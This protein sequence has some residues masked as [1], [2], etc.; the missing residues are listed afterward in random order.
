MKALTWHGKGDVRCEHVPDPIIQD[1]HDAIIKVTACVICESDVHLYDSVIP[2][3]K[4]G[5]VLD[6]ETMGEVDGSAT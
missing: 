2:S 6:H 4:S 1:H 3:L 5:D